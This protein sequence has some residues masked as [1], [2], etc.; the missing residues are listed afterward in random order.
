MFTCLGLL[1]FLS[2]P[3]SLPPP[4][5]SA[6][7]LPSPLSPAEKLT[8]ILQ[9]MLSCEVVGLEHGSFHKS[10]KM[11]L[12]HGF[13]LLVRLLQDKNSNVCARSRY[14]I[15]SIKESA[16]EVC[17]IVYM[18]QALY[19]FGY[20]LLSSRYRYY[21]FIIREGF[22]LLFQYSKFS[23]RKNLSCPVVMRNLHNNMLAHHTVTKDDIGLH[24]YSC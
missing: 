14:C 18:V 11:S 8:S 17:C 1:S 23:V 19:C 4:L 22:I 6:T 24:E 12:A 10:L 21:S 13:C 16:L 3:S 15:T 2:H 20:E 5:L 9:F 7:S